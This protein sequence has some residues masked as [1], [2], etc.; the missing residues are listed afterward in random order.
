M[1]PHV[2]NAWKSRK[3]CRKVR[4]FK[5]PE[6]D[7]YR[8]SITRRLST[9]RWTSSSFNQEIVHGVQIERFREISQT[10]LFEKLDRR[11][12][13][14]ITGEKNNA[15]REDRIHHAQ[16]FVEVDAAAAR[17]LDICDDEVVLVFLRQ[18]QGIT[19]IAGR[20]DEIAL[21]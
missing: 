18:L 15:R 9:K 11:R 6:R 7:T 17:H 12:V 4:S 2:K 3:R 8:T 10:F 14:R 21:P 5:F 19:N 1:M 20:V 16:P 13:A